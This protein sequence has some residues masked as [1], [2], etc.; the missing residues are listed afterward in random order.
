MP[1]WLIWFLIFSWGGPLGLGVFLAGMGV[2]YW[3]QSR[4]KQAQKA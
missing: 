1:E 3:G 4:M 2:F